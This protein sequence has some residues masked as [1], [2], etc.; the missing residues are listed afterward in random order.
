[1]RG[2]EDQSVATQLVK[3]NEDSISFPVTGM[4]CAACQSR[5]QRALAAEA[6]VLDASVNLV[7]KR[8]A[9]RYDP[10]AVSP[11]RLIEAVRATGYDAQL[12]ALDENPSDVASRQEDADEREAREL[13]IKATVSVVAGILAMGISMPLIGSALAN[14]SLLGLTTTILAWAGR[15]IYRR[16]WKAVRH[17]SADMNTLV[18]LGTGSAFLY[19]VIATIAPSLFSRNGIAPDVYYEAV[20]FIIGL[21]LAGRAIEARARRKTSEALRKL[22]TLLPPSAHVEEDGRWLEKPLA[23]V[24]SGEIVV[25]RPGERIPVDGMLVE[26]ASEVDES[27]LTGE[28]L[29]VAKSV[30]DRVVGGTLNT[31]GAFRYRATSVGADSVLARIVRLMRDAQSSRAPIQ[32]LAD[33]VSAVF[34]PVV[35]TIAIATFLVWYFAAGSTALPRAIAAAVSVLIIACPCAMGLAVPT[36]VMVA[37]GR[38]AEMGLLIKGGEVLQRAGDVD[39]VVLDKTGTVTEGAPAVARVIALG[40]LSDVEVLGRAAALERHSEHPVAAAIVR[41]ARDKEV[42]LDPV[43]EFQSHTGSG[44]TGK[45]RGR[46]VAVGNIQLMREL[47]IAVEDPR[48]ENG[49]SALEGEGEGEGSSK[50]LVATDG[51]I[52][53]VIVVSDSLRPSSREAVQRLQA[54]G[55]DVLLLTGDRLTTAEAIAREIGVRRVVAEVLPQGKVAEIRGLQKLGRV[56]AMVGDGINDAPALAQSDVGISMPKGTDIA[57]EASDIALMRSD[58]RGVPTAISLSRKTMATMKQNLF[59]AFVYN[60]IGIPIAAG[61]LYPVTGLM[62]SPIIASAAMAL[63][64]V[65]VVTNSLR[66]RHARVT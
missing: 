1:L 12:P 24:R 46:D 37:T 25:V 27:M 44:V 62:L 42:A 10:V 6:G 5:V 14:Y 48:L 29:P 38:G 4:T 58:L 63:S 9:V 40:T 7:T 65:S 31:T 22:V 30:G 11:A 2:E 28:P 23:E 20:I 55:V 32:R 59:W 45:V 39:T 61:V 41:A 16:A 36:A 56:V 18:A 3:S 50:L 57:I 66:L 64:S 60:V 54:M 47:G 33:K 17:R 43:T 51:R 19:S 21:V 34:V 13:A 26:G 35:L 49:S 15:D 52:A 53:G 8:A